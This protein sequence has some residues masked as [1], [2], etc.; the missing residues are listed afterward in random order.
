MEKTRSAQSKK[1]IVLVFGLYDDP[2]TSR[3]LLLFHQYY[4][5]K[6][7]L[8]RLKLKHIN[9]LKDLNWLAR[10]DAIFVSLVGEPRPG[11]IEE[12][13]LLQMKQNILLLNKSNSSMSDLSKL[14]VNVSIS[15]KD[16][17]KNKALSSKNKTS[18]ASS[19]AA[20]F[21]NNNI[22]ETDDINVLIKNYNSYFQQVTY[23]IPNNNLLARIRRSGHLEIM[24]LIVSWI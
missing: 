4:A 9:I 12:K 13:K 8:P 20:V 23:A 15:D 11:S 6:N 1:K 2:P 24:Q 5:S 21:V 22:I 16:Y 14:M 17:N 7:I 10:K 18:K 19:K 3:L